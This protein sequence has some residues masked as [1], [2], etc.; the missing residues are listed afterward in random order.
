M[1]DTKCS[2]F[3]HRYFRKVCLDCGHTEASP[4]LFQAFEPDS[5]LQDIAHHVA[6]MYATG[7]MTHADLAACNIA[8]YRAC[9]AEGMDEP[10][11]G[12]D[13]RVYCYARII[14][15]AQS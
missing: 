4:V 11:P 2:A 15:A 8:D 6:R 12:D 7:D 13:A 1:T 14:E 3:G 9:R 5:I 10:H